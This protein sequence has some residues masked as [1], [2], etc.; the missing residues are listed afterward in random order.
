MEVEPEVDPVVAAV[1]PPKVKSEEDPFGGAVARG[2]A[3]SLEELSV[4][5]APK[6]NKDEDGE[7]AAMVDVD[8]GFELGI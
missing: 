2:F 5:F 1:P 3:A 6:L 4:G 8:D 7:T